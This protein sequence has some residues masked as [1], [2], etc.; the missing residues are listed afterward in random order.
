MPSASGISNQSGP[1][2]FF[3]PFL[4]WLRALST[5]SLAQGSGG[6]CKG[7]HLYRLPSRS[8]G[9][10]ITVTGLRMRWGLRAFQSHCLLKVSSLLDKLGPV[11]EQR[12]GLLGKR[13]AASGAI[14]L[15]TLA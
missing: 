13:L 15:R 3:F 8:G 11:K 7:A 12:G 1:S 4:H 6:S 5:V 10:I 14:A 9:A 2:N